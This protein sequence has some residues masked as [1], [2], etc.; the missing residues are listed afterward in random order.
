LAVLGPTT[1]REHGVVAPLRPRE[2]HV[3]AALALTHPR[4]CSSDAL[5][6]ALWDTVPNTA[7]KALQSHV[8]R[9]RRALGDDAIVTE[10]SSYRL[11]PGWVLDTERFDADLS[12]ARRGALA[13]DDA[14]ARVFLQK[15]LSVVHGQA[16]ADLSESAL[17]VAE[18][19][20][21]HQLVAAAED[22]LALALLSSNETS[23]AIVHASALVENDPYSERR[24]MALALGLFRDEQRRES[25]VAL[26]RGRDALR[27]TGLDA[28]PALINL[29]SMILA[30]DPR[31]NGDPATLIGRNTYGP[32]PAAT[33]A[34]I[35]VGRDD[36]FESVFQMLFQSLDDR[37][38]RTLEIVAAAG[39]GKS[40]FA[41]RVSLRA[42]IDGWHVFTTAC[43]RTPSRLLEPV[44][45]LAKQALD[46]EPNP[47]DVFDAEL[48]ADLAALWT[49][50]PQ[51]TARGDL[52]EAVVDTIVHHAG[53]FATLLI[54]DDAQ[55]L[56]S[57]A[58]QLLR[59]MVR[60]RVPLVVL[61][62]TNTPSKVAAPGATEPVVS[63]LDV[64]GLDLSATRRLLEMLSGDVASADFAAAVHVATGGNPDVIRR[65][66]LAE[67]ARD[68]MDGR[69]IPLSMDRIGIAALETMSIAAQRMAPLLA[70]AGGPLSPSAI[71]A[72]LD[73]L[74]ESVASR[75]VAEAVRG[76]I[77]RIDI[78][79]RVELS[80]GGLR[81]A[82]MASID[83]T[84]LID[85]HE[86]VGRALSAAGAGPLAVAPHFLAAA[87]NNR[88][89]AIEVCAEAGALSRHASMFI[90]AGEFYEQAAQQSLALYG[91]TDQRTFALL[92]EQSECLR[93]A[94][95]PSSTT[96]VWHVAHEAERVGDSETL[97][98]AAAA[99]CRLGPLTDAGS[100]DPVL[101]ALVERAI[102]GCQSENIRA[103]LAGQ[104]TLLYSMS[105]QADVCREYFDIALSNARA[106]NDPDALLDAL[107]NAYTSL[108]H[109]DDWPL[110]AELAS[111]MLALAEG[112]HR[113]D[114]LFEA[115]HMLFSTQVQNN[116]PLLRTTF[117][118]QVALAKT[119]RAAGLRWMVGYQSACLAV[120]DGRLDEAVAISSEHLETSPVARSRS[121]AT[122]W[123]NMFVV[124]LAQ[125]RGQELAAD[126]DAVID[127][128]AGLP[129]WRTVAAWLAALRGDVDRVRAECDVLDNGLNLPRD[130][131]W[132]GAL[133]ILG[134]AVAA[135]GDEDR[136]RVITD[137]I[138]PYSG[139]TTWIGS[140]T[141]GPFDLALAEMALTLG[142]RAA[143]R[144]YLDG[145]QRSIHRLGAKVFQRELDELAARL[146]D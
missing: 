9:I 87:I 31:L 6:E 54:V 43:R 28:G 129:A 60:A 65:L 81:D 21:R 105:G 24:W 38:A 53:R 145:A 95:H 2:H 140:Y 133:M 50:A 85:L 107:G 18:R 104:A 138:A 16:F 58:A 26:R 132:S 123:M 80:G 143:A 120:L 98:L 101:A 109:P 44:G 45:A 77:F 3:L 79:Q 56:T 93:R 30:D 125:G 29:E 97:A 15:A 39:M 131:S 62:L 42:A 91:S 82:L 115:L 75:A 89:R 74:D 90:E 135:I 94:G 73:D 71:V 35:F 144:R 136:C 36:L 63:R 112:L 46:H 20:R 146:G 121:I 84:T 99:L 5:I 119:L 124:R 128:Q 41:H 141:V 96:V 51:M 13:G 139:L 64:G 86:R 108:A 113:D 57:T 25:L 100:L 8:A 118:R 10:A 49:N 52:G 134:R 40:A 137:L 117:A 61:A 69:L 55:Y 116:D 1:V 114:A 33:T 23:A 34:D 11:G 4:A 88:A 68:S 32:T 126:I 59:Q 19:A 106:S 47:T 67:R 130:M 22:E 37:T 103:R 17:V 92:L 12:H 7:T 111:E 66:V 127:A 48:L 70:V 78:D 72:A 83:T 142:D 76:G 122:Y 14:V 27:E 110:R 102:A